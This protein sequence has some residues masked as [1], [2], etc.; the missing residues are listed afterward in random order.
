M[1]QTYIALE[2]GA[3]DRQVHMN[4]QAKSRIDSNVPHD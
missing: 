1:L 2:A 4:Q 3:H